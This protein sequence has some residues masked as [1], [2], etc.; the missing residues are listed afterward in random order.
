MNYT[1]HD[2]TAYGI[3]NGISATD[4]RDFTAREASSLGLELF[5]YSCD[6]IARKLSHDPE[7]EQLAQDTYIPFPEHDTWSDEAKNYHR[8]AVENRT[9]PGRADIPDDLIYAKIRAELRALA[10]RILPARQA[11]A[12]SAER[13]RMEIMKHIKNIETEKTDIFD[14]GG[15]T[16]CFTHRVTMKSGAV[17]TFADRNIFD[18][19]RVINPCY[20]ILPDSDPGGIVSKLDDGTLS[21]SIS[22]PNG[23]FIDARPLSEDEIRA[24]YAIVNYCGFA[25]PSQR[26]SNYIRM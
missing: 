10:E 8:K 15:K 25:D 23:G 1:I 3:Y 26:Q 6:E 22:G 14:E 19:G 21:W 24:Y 20:P 17:F 7:L 12:E 11:A 16:V 9:A 18:V 2:M 13:E 5:D 4:I